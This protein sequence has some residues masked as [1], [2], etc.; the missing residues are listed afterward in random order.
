MKKSHGPEDNIGPQLEKEGDAVLG[1]ATEMEVADDLTAL[2]NL[3]NDCVEQKLPLNAETTKEV[4]ERLRKITDS[5]DIGLYFDYGQVHQN[6]DEAI[7][8]HRGRLL[9][10]GFRTRRMPMPVFYIHPDKWAGVCNEKDYFLQE[11]AL[12]ILRQHS[13]E[14]LELITPPGATKIRIYDFGVGTGEK[15]GIITEE[16]VKRNNESVEYHGVDASAEMLRIAMTQIAK[17]FIEEALNLKASDIH[18]RHASP[19]K[20]L[21]KFL[22]NYNLKYSSLSPAY[23]EKSFARIFSEHYKHPD[24][25]LIKHLFARMVSLHKKDPKQ[26]A[27][28]NELDDDVQLP[29][30][31]HAHPKW[32][33]QFKKEEFT[34]RENEGVVIF[35][36]GSNVCNQPLDQSVKRFYD[37][38]A[39]PD[40]PDSNPDGLIPLKDETDIKANYA[41]LG[42]QL[43]EIPQ[44]QKRF[45]ELHS[46]I[47]KAYNNPAFRALTSDPFLQGD[48]EYRDLYSGETLNF[49]DIGF[50]YVDY[51]EDKERPGY[52][53]AT[54]RLYITEDVEILNKR[55]ESIVI[56]GKEKA[57]NA[58]RKTVESLFAGRKKKIRGKGKEIMR[59]LRVSSKRELL[60]VDIKTFF[61]KY[62]GNYGN[63][64]KIAEDVLKAPIDLEQILLYPSYKPSLEQIVTLCHEGGLKVIKVFGD[65]ED[66][67]TYCKILTRK[68]TSAEQQA[69]SEGNRDVNIFFN[70]K[71]EFPKTASKSKIKGKR[72]A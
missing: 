61:S 30:S 44:T 66:N 65:N 27:K 59:K 13:N 53:L 58:F 56:K 64:M 63:G 29:I 25:D 31:M 38:L 28:I 16:A 46:K 41:V 3:I 69:Y 8:E 7:S 11:L 35:D 1:V 12:N 4:L 9:F 20:D 15:G 19:W 36:L 57:H 26:R 14:M 23:L 62:Y 42:L 32:F 18:T 50:I 17:T 45:R 37:V 71:V 39:E 47:T 21:V 51:E 2:R 48:I 67:P 49:E 5:S 34:L 68:M 72:R 43:G 33:E 52:Y 6:L 54:H 40:I 10:E 24:L 22:R 70:P 60:K 55:G